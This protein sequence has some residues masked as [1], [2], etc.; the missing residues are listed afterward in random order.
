M[1]LESKINMKNELQFSP[2][3][4]E[5]VQLR[6]PPHSIEAETCVLGGLL[7]SNESFAEIQSI[8]SKD[9]FYRLE[10][11]LI[12]SSIKGL[13]ESGRP[14]DVITVFEHL[15]A[16]GKGEEIG[17]IQYLNSIAQYVPSS[18]HLR[19][20]ATLVHEK[21]LLRRLISVGEK[22]SSA[23]FNQDGRSVEELISTAEQQV[24][25][26]GRG[27]SGKTT[28]KTIE[29]VA[30]EIID[31]LQDRAEN[32]SKFAGVRTG[33]ED[34]DEMIGGF[35]AGELIVVAGRPSMG[36]TSLVMNI[37]ENA[38]TRNG[39]QSLVISLEMK[40]SA[41]A[42]RMLGA[43]GRVNQS[44][45]KEP[46]KLDAQDWARISD[47]LEQVRNKGIDFEDSGVETIGAIRSAARR[48]FQRN[49]R[50][51]L[52]V[53]DY[54]QLLDGDT[55]A[56]RWDNRNNEVSKISRGLKLLAQ[57]M[58]CPV[59][60]LSQLTRNVEQR[61]DKRPMMSDLRDSGAIEQ[62]SD[63]IMMIY[64]DDYYTR[65]ASKEPGVAEI[66][67]AKQRNGETGVVRL[68][69]SPHYTR[70]DSLAF[71]RDHA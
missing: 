18:R 57:E 36:K 64:R 44:K 32:P 31:Q 47:A 10:H 7:L 54:L 11:S 6:V 70:F 71:S 46:K 29:D 23:A 13:V 39:L 41:I 14:A 3:E 37:V 15:C 30:I 59:I 21:A 53:V 17:G 48:S 61:P 22:I 42:L 24:L 43:I 20:Y 1:R 49:K 27:L 5:G 38:S 45:L 28:H 12:Y 68:A 50:L 63:T 25:E 65:E 66:N 67:I 52:I 58:N 2:Q 56:G 4:H 69:W 60:A 55:D 16:R 19:H 51:D 35:Q 33:Y 9:Q 26:V 40:S 62:D 8:L 34:L